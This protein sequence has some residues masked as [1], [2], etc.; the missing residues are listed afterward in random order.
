MVKQ[1][2]DDLE[3][4]YFNIKMPLVKKIFI[5]RLKTA[6]KLASLKDDS[7]VLDVGCYKGYLLKMIQNLGVTNLHGIDISPAILKP[8]L[9]CDLRNADVRNIPYDDKYFDIVFVLDVLEHVTD[10]NKAIK[11]INRVLKP[12]AFAIMS[13][14][15]ESLFYVLGRFL[16]KRKTKFEQH[17]CSVYEVEEMF[18]PNGFQLIEQKSLPSFPLPQLFRISKYKKIS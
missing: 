4:D 2:I 13:G 12:N 17:V 18:P 16:W 11:E 3:E 8:L 7:I 15:T 14:P 6:I 1:Q 10:V 5:N 9:D